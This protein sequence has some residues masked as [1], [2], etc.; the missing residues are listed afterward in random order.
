MYNRLVL[1]MYYLKTA[2]ESDKLG[3][4]DKLNERNIRHHFERQCVVDPKV[5]DRGN[6]IIVTKSMD[7]GRDFDVDFFYSAR[8][9]EM[10]QKRNITPEKLIERMSLNATHDTAELGKRSVYYKGSLFN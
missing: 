6:E 1:E 3:I 10:M 4:V 5:F 9:S 8:R 7:Y 2:E